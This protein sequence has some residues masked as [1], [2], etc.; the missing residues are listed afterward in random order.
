VW[1]ARRTETPRSRPHATCWQLTS[2][3]L[4]LPHHLDLEVALSHQ[5]LEPR[6]LHSSCFKRRTSLGSI[7]P[8]RL[9]HVQ[10]VCSLMPCRWRSLPPPAISRPDYR[11]HLLFRKA[12]FTHHPLREP[13]SQVVD[14]PKSQGQVNHAPWAE[15]VHPIWLGSSRKL[16]RSA[17]EQRGVQKA[18]GPS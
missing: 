4:R 8:K 14:G 5:L 7:P 9:R 10:I 12:R 11:E 1:Q 16:P 18:V 13:V 2:F 6:T 15:A 3:L 17:E